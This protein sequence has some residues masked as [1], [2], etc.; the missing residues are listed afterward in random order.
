MTNSFLPES[1]TAAFPLRC[2]RDVQQAE[3]ELFRLTRR[4]GS[5][6][7][8]QVRDRVDAILHAV[9]DRGDAAV[10]EFTERFDGFN[11][12][13]MAVPEAQLKQAWDGLSDNLRDAL[14]LAHR[15]ICEFH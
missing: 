13:P 8:R 2:V 5:S 11:P 7:Q 3:E 12:Q 10:A 1:S 15:R 6:Q 9:R 4:T 14:D